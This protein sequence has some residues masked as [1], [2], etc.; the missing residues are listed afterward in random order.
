MTLETNFVELDGAVEKW[1][2]KAA[3]LVGDTFGPHGRTVFVNAQAGRYYATKDGHAAMRVLY[4]GESVQE[5][6]PVGSVV[7]SL[8]REATTRVVRRSGD[9][10]TSAVLAAADLHRRFRAAAGRRPGAPPR[11]MWAAL[12]KAADEVRS[13]MAERFRRPAGPGDMLRVA[14]ISANGDEELASMIAEIAEKV[15]A[16]GVIRMDRSAAAKTTWEPKP[17]FGLHRGLAGPQFASERDAAGIRAEFEDSCVFLCDGRLDREDMARLKPLVEAVF[18]GE[19]EMPD[20]MVIVANGFDEVHVLKPLGMFVAGGRRN[21]QAMRLA[22]IDYATD[23]APQLQGFLD[24]AAWLGARPYL[25]RTEA[26][27]PELG[28]AMESLGRCGGFSANDRSTQFVD[29][30]GD[31]EAVD[32]RKEVIRTELEALR[33]KKEDGEDV[34]STAISDLEMRIAALEN[35]VAEIRVAGDSDAETESRR[36]LA[37]DAMFACRSA[38]RGGVSAGACT[39]PARAAQIA[40]GAFPEGSVEREM[41][42]LLE[43]VFQGLYYKVARPC[44]PS[45]AETWGMVNRTLET[46]HEVWNAAK[47]RIE[48]FGDPECEV[49]CPAETDDEVLDAAVSLMGTLATAGRLAASPKAV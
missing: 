18:S 14:R 47:R 11:E 17:G 32:S 48:R 23:S 7:L 28:I 46:D 16:D 43:S 35:R 4:P 38:L 36:F 25:K 27:R 41:A 24:L 33:R 37:E 10:T 13:I 45:E 34:A 15:G 19:S 12:R 44:F 8:L 39:A 42:E 26:E 9:G 40:R 29:G 31:A 1:L 49:L 5:P 22:V 2:D 3:D 21:G 30:K 6:D 20:S